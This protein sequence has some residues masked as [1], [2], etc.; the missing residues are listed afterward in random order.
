VALNKHLPTFGQILLNQI[1]IFAKFTAVERFYIKEA[2]LPPL[3][4][5][6]TSGSRV[7]RP[8]SITLLRFAMGASPA[9]EDPSPGQST[10]IHTNT[11]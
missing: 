11:N 2:T 6:R 7:N 1:R 9:P 10:I 5:V 3:E 8:I 4:N